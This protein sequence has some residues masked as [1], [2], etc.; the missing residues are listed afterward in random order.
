MDLTLAALLPTPYSSVNLRV[1]CNTTESRRT[2]WW[3]WGHQTE[4]GVSSCHDIDVLLRGTKVTSSLSGSFQSILR[5]HAPLRERAKNTLGKLSQIREKFEENKSIFADRR[6]TVFCA[7]SIGRKDSG[8]HS[9][10]DLFVVADEEVNQ[11]DTYHFFAKLISINSEL[12]YDKFSNDGEFLKVYQLDDLTALTGTREEDSQ[13]V[14]TARMLLLLESTPAC[15]DDL[16]NEF[17]RRVIN[18]YCRDEKEHNSSF[19][20]LFLLNDLLRYWRTLCLNYEKIRHDPKKPW[21]KKNVNL[22]FSRMLTV[23]GTVLPLIAG[24][25]SSHQ[26]IIELCQ[27]SPLERLS[28]GLDVLNAPELEGEF[29]K[30]L[31]NYEYFLKLKEE[32]EIMDDHD[33]GKRAV[34]D[35]KAN[36]F[37]SFLYAAHTHRNVPIEYRKYLVI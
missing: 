5:E 8:K 6:V 11:L 2:A 36:Q 13:N 15:N 17:L 27:L 26:E 25:E 19:K 1:R 23:Y 12:G 33:L 3:R 31:E 29:I 4:A 32:E 28:K 37:S 35:E 14:F 22:K 24:T 34:L 18:H 20:P 30:F 10:L 9:D 16:Y 21:R 7:G